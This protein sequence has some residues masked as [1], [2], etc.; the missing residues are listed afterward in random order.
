MAPI[1]KV[2]ATSDKILVLANVEQNT[3]D[4]LQAMGGTFVLKNK[5]GKEEF[6]LALAE[7][8][9][10]K[11]YYLAVSGKSTIVKQISI[12]SCI[13]ES[14]IKE[15]VQAVALEFGAVQQKAEKA[16]KELEKEYEIRKNQAKKIEVE[17]TFESKEG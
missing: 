10:A 11:D 7:A 15:A 14:E 17:Y 12:P 1:F 2:S 4:A 9:T 5:E 16:I 6:R 8:S 13:K 3:L